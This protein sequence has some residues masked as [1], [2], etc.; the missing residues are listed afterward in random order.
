MKRKWLAW[1]LPLLLLVVGLS[2]TWLQVSMMQEREKEVVRE[3]FEIRT[4]ELV[5]GLERRMLSQAQILLGVA[6]VFDS[7]DF[8][9]RSEFQR[10][11]TSLRLGENYPGVQGVGYVE[12]FAANQKEKHI[13]EIRAQ[14]LA[15]YTIR[16]AGE[17][18]IYSSVVYVEPF[19]WR[20][21]RALGFDMLLEPIRVKAAMRAR[22]EGRVVTSDKV[23]L[24]QETSQDVQAG[25]LLFAPLY[26][27]GHMPQSL[28]ERREALRG[29][30]YM[31]MRIGDFIDSYLQQEYP[32]LSKQIILQVYSGNELRE[33]TLMYRSGGEDTAVTQTPAI[34]R[35][36]I[37][38]GGHWTVSLTPLAAYGTGWKF[39]ERSSTVVLAGLCLTALLSLMSYLLLKS[40]MR[41][42]DALQEATLSHEQMLEKEEQIRHMAHHDILTGLPNRALFIDRA[43]QAFT[44]A[45]RNQ[46][47]VAVLFIDL[48][49][50]KPINDQYGHDAGDV[51]LR[52]IGK[53]LQDRLRASDTVCRQG[54]DEFVILLPEVKE[55]ADLEKLA[56]KL[57]EAIE[58]PCEVAGNLLMVSASIGIALY[59]EHGEAVETVIQRADAAMYQAKANAAK[60]VCFAST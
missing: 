34:A 4:G 9:T 29:W 47:S 19:N 59:P 35:R 45:Y 27:G 8:V 37:V 60:P 5:A 1:A 20:N 57:R 18:E 6:G 49:R 21:Q 28:E 7:S 54:G 15:D 3:E 14:G 41:V 42:E 58:E 22:D 48:D 56:Y 31:P 46:Q 33:E 24:V 44:L 11:Y 39:D 38:P 26:Q 55:R 2:V 25:V 10:Y 32:E 40:H 50:F 53:R 13:A 52:M 30:V 23:V 12:L 36:A 17:R 43:E 51:V 16:P